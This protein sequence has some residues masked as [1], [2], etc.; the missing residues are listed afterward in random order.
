M[1]RI[2]QNELYIATIDAAI[3]EKVTVDS[4]NY[5]LYMCYPERND[6]S[7]CRIKRVEYAKVGDVETYTT[8][9]PNGDNHYIYDWSQR[10]VYTYEI[11]R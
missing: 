5:T 11:K 10:A 7:K 3:V 8:T 2:N 4:D 6:T 1:P 9:Y